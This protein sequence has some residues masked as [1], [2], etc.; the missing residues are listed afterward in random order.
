[1]T[2]VSLPFARGGIKGEVRKI[3]KT[4]PPNLISL[5]RILRQ[6][7]TPW[8]AKLWKYLRANGLGVK[9]KRQVRLGNYFVD[10][11]CASRRLIIELDGGHHSESIIS[12]HD[13][14]RQQYLE[15]EGYKVLRFWN[16]EL[17][18]NL[19][20]VLEVIRSEIGEPLSQPLP[21]SGERS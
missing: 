3:M 20:G 8:E 12:L 21:S 18:Q 1:M 11:Y 7:Q 9:F 4:I 5:S 16:N 13:S 10:F 2:L 14:S 15:K 17:D 19:A 6:K